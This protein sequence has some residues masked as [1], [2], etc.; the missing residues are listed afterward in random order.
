SSVSL[1]TPSTT[2]YRGPSIPL[3]C[4]LILRQAPLLATWPQ[5]IRRLG[6][7]GGEVRH[8]ELLAR[9]KNC[10]D[11]DAFV[12]LA[13]LAAKRSPSELRRVRYTSQTLAADQLTDAVFHGWPV[14]P[15]IVGPQFLWR[16]A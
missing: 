13:S 14:Q 6:N 7:R 9:Q 16:A 8:L 12:V 2:L 11:G 1:G 3:A 10:H 15:C 4:R 5:R